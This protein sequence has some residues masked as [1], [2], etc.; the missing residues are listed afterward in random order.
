[1]IEKG[2]LKLRLMSSLTKDDRLW[3]EE[4]CA[5][6]ER[7]MLNLL[8]EACGVRCPVRPGAGRDISDGAAGAHKFCNEVKKTQPAGCL[9]FCEPIRA[10]IG[11]TSRL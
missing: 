6:H 4:T 1:M 10:L 5:D 8:K 2:S 9:F 7:E 3:K 11:I